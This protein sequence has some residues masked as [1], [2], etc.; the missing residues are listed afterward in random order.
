MLDVCP[1]A[2]Q[3]SSYRIA[4]LELESDELDDA[5]ASE[6]TEQLR[7]E[8]R[9]RDDVQ[10]HDTRV[11]L[12]QLSL[13][14]DC[15]T[16]EPGCLGQI[17]RGLEV[18]GFVFG[19]LTHEG[20]APVV[21]LRRYDSARAAVDRSALATFVQRSVSKGELDSASNKLIAQ[22]LGGAAAASA[23]E[24]EELPRLQLSA[25]PVDHT[26]PLA[27]QPEPKSSALSG[28]TIAGYA[29]LGGA[30]LSVGASVLSFVQVERSEKDRDFERYR[31]A[32][33]Q[34]GTS[35]NDVCDEA[36][37]GKRYG[38]ETASFRHVKS[39]CNTGI[40]FEA[41]QFVFIGTAVVSGGLAAYFLTSGES[42]EKQKPA[43]GSSNF[44]VAPTFARRGFGVGARL[45]F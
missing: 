41:L 21:V 36:S 10:L 43:L 25:T 6:L 12:A 26:P 14:R 37:A 31:L 23:A 34:R 44:S 22:L 15:N 33:G 5:L 27:A 7:T 13:A 11:S 9:T 30:A 8:L 20:G 38:L 35:V 28:R 2:A 19:K 4:V 17:A 1:L 16:S 39:V 24:P 32:V 45:K 3:V 29:L 18:D 40:L 42:A